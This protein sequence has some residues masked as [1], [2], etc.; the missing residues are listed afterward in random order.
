[1]AKK[2]YGFAWG[3]IAGGVVG[4]VTALLL[5][6]KSG[7]ELRSDIGEYAVKAADTAVEIGEIIGDKA[8]AAARQ[9]AAGATALKEKAI[10]TADTLASGIKFWDRSE[11]R[12][13]AVIA[14]ASAAGDSD[15]SDFILD[16][17]LD[18]IDAEDDGSGKI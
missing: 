8:A 14:S 10:Q 6:P 12:E 18:A 9:T 7:R 5:A 3:A 16:E 2:K 1:M 13:L 15:V 11:D 4:S 17:R